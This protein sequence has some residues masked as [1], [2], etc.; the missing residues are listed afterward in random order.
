L[1]FASVLGTYG[2]SFFV[3]TTSALAVLCFIKI[4]EL[5]FWI[6][7]ALFALIPY[8]VGSIS[9]QIT[10][11]R[12]AFAPKAKVALVQTGW[13]IEERG[14]MENW[15]EEFI[16]PLVQ[17]EIIF[18]LLKEIK[19][20][21]GSFDL[22]VLPETAVPYLE[23][24]PLFW[25]EDFFYVFQKYFSLYEWEKMALEQKPFP[26]KLSHRWIAQFI[27]DHFEADLLLG[28]DSINRESMLVY[29]SGF[30]FTPKD[31]HFQ[32]YDKQKLLPI[33]ECLPFAFLRSIAEKYGITHFFTPG[34]NSNI[35]RG[36]YKY[37]PSVC[38]DECFSQIG[39]LQMKENPELLVNFTNDGWFPDSW[40]PLAHFLH[41]KLRSVE[42]GRSALRACNYGVTCSLDPLGRSIDMLGHISTSSQFKQGAVFT[43][44]PLLQYNT[45]YTT[46]GE[47]PIFVLLLL[48]AAL[49]ALKRNKILV[50]TL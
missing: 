26:Q 40:L 36:R 19:R 34:K 3:M 43:S 6:A 1:Q 16:H 31:P 2:L 20:E 35:L 12:M 25:K 5:K 38:Y 8:V 42:L 50:S 28:M 24:E 13:K 30:L 15:E 29:S 37:A 39:R 21:K 44:V 33:A 10:L 27:A 32:K 46:L 17:W 14:L 23:D 22:M 47:V 48:S 7:F 45:L 18:R 9:F 4:K 41:G 11:H 49:I